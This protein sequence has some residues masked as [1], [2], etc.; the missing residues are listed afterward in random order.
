MKSGE[1]KPLKAT[2]LSWQ[3]V[4]LSP[5]LVAWNHLEEEPVLLVGGHSQ[6]LQA[7]ERA[8]RAAGGTLDANT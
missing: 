5:V 6:L 3:H 1:Q 8:S 2:G 7:G 4:C